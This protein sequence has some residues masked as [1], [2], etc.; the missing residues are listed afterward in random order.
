MD[1]S[2]NDKPA[3]QTQQTSMTTR[4]TW[5]NETTINQRNKLR[6]LARTARNP[7]LQQKMIS[8]TTKLED[9]P[10]TPMEAVCK[11]EARSLSTHHPTTSRKSSYTSTQFM[12]AE[13]FPLTTPCHATQGDKVLSHFLLFLPFTL[14]VHSPLPCFQWPPAKAGGPPFRW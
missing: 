6:R 9:R 2:N 11:V 10:T 8:T 4:N 7:S 3:K 14:S 1:D 13:Q 5:A 12:Y